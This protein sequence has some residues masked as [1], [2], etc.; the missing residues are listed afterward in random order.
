[1]D[2]LSRGARWIHAS[3]GPQYD[4]MLTHLFYATIAKTLTFT[5]YRSEY[6]YL[7]AVVNSDEEAII[8]LKSSTSEE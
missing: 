8:L 3:M 4:A 1:M 7:Y 5:I 6:S 2:D